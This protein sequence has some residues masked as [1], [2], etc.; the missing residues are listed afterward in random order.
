MNSPKGGGGGGDDDGGAHDGD[1]ARVSALERTEE[2]KTFPYLPPVW[3]GRVGHLVPCSAPSCCGHVAGRYGAEKDD[4]MRPGVDR[5]IGKTFPVLHF[6]L[7][8]L[9]QPCF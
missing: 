8:Q 9:T 5:V 1:G 3:I 4:H 7:S 2:W 6:C